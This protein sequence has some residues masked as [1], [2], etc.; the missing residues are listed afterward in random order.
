MS[1]NE[2]ER[3]INNEPSISSLKDSSLPTK[4]SEESLDWAKQVYAK[5]KAKQEADKLIEQRKELKLK[6]ENALISQSLK[7]T[8]VKL[9]V[10]KSFTPVS[11]TLEI[12][13]EVK[14]STGDI[15]QP[16][17]GEMDENFEQL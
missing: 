17:L 9:D 11:P 14:I 8:P 15:D 1:Y 3:T 4:E 7:D 2:F 5:L 10:E 13:N 6:N 16:V 12:K